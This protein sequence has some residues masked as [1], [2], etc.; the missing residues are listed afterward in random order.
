MKFRIKSYIIGIWIITILFFISSFL[1]CRILENKSFYYKNGEILSTSWHDYF[2]RIAI[3]L[4]IMI[5]IIIVAVTFL[6][7]GGAV[8]Y[9]VNANNTAIVIG[10]LNTD[11]GGRN[12]GNYEIKWLDE[13]VEITYNTFNSADSKLTESCKFVS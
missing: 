2:K 12:H 8:V 5:S 1:L 10:S 6:L 7:N 13:C 11:D 4:C 3:I 9:Q